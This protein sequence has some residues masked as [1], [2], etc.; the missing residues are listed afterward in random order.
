MQVFP[1]NW[2]AEIK[3][4]GVVEAMNKVD[5]TAEI[6]GQ[7][8]KIVPEFREGAFVKKGQALAYIDDV[9]NNRNLA[10]ALQELADA[11]VNFLK[12]ERKTRQS[13]RDWARLGKGK[14]P[15]SELVLN[16]PQLD[17]AKARL[18]AAATDVELSQRNLDKTVVRSPFDAVV[19]K[20]N[21]NLGQV[22]STGSSMATLMEFAKSQ[23]RFQITEHKWG[24][25]ADDLRLKLESG[26]DVDMKMEISDPVV[27]VTRWHSHTTRMGGERNSKTRQRRLITQIDSPNA[28]SLLPGTFVKAV[29]KGE[30]VNNVLV[31]PSSAIS[32]EGYL[33]SVDTEDRLVRHPVKIL[34]TTA[35]KS[36]VQL[37]VTPESLNV[38]VAPL[39]SMLVGQAVSP[40]DLSADLGN[41]S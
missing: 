18:E 7:V 2:Q 1:T 6:T 20:R 25:I 36:F 26:M 34:G 16:I 17:A 11:K 37:K 39:A 29:F 32:V 22:L 38:V 31:V 13:K 30:L 35:E 41:A 23:V 14:K 4:N 28:Q 27:G 21:L 3:I 5:L 33:W 10:K 8:V 40:I 15:G 24:L 12:E 9:Q 19:L